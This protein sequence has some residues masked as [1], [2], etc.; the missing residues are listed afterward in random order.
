MLSACT[1]GVKLMEIEITPVEANINDIILEEYSESTL[2]KICALN[3][4]IHEYN[5]AYPIECIR[6]SVNGYRVIYRGSSHIALIWFDEAGEKI[7]TQLVELRN[8]AADY[9]E[10]ELGETLETVRSMYPEGV[11]LFGSTGRNDA[12]RISSHYTID[13]YIVYISYD[14][15]YEVESITTELI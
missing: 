10:I 9:M 1:G 7:Y 6:N 11:Y 3:G 14:S 5:R 15:N 4:N 8:T 12:P 13:G 2:K